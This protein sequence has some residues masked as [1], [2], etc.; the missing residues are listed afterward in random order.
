MIFQIQNESVESSILNILQ[1]LKEKEMEQATNK[2]IRNTTANA[3]QAGSNGGDNNKGKGKG[4]EGNKGKVCHQCQRTGHLKATCFTMKSKSGED[5][6]SNGVIQ[7]PYK[8]KT[9]AVNAW[10]AN[11]TVKDSLEGQVWKA[12]TIKALINL[13]LPSDSWIVDS[14]VSHH[15]SPDQSLFSMIQNYS[16]YVTLVNEK[17]IK[18]TDIRKVEVCFKGKTLT[19]IDILFVSELDGNLLSIEAVSKHSITVKFELINIVFKHNGVIV[20]TA[21]QHGSVYVIESTNRKAV[22]KVQVSEKSM[23]SLAAPATAE[24]G[25]PILELTSELVRAVSEKVGD[26]FKTASAEEVLGPDTPEI[27]KL[28]NQPQTDYWKWHW[29]FSHVEAKH[30]QCL[31][32]CVEGIALD[33]RSNETE[34]TYSTCLHGKMICVQ[35]R[36]TLSRATHHLQQVY[37]DM[38]GLYWHK[39]LGENCYFVTFTDEFSQYSELFLMENKLNVYNIFSI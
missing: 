38:W 9:K 39:S 6:A 22:F 10:K 18:V 23:K 26:P 36:E 14:E 27:S 13:K 17:A 31:Q 15:M 19:L 37:S 28:L 2:L 25:V 24:G 21:N 35:I 16:T 33:L 29:R 1:L 4:K 7:P 20:A 5:L 8:P 3:A 32:P 34:K 12:V 30:L 11:E